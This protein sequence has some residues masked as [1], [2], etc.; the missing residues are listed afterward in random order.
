MSFQGK[1]NWSR[2]IKL[3][4]VDSTDVEEL[5]AAI[6]Q[7]EQQGDSKQ[8]G[9]LRSMHTAMEKFQGFRE[10]FEEYLEAVDECGLEMDWDGLGEE[11]AKT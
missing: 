11:L 8:C 3:W 7:L 1:A 4:N 2:P 9:V 10:A 6:K 5:E